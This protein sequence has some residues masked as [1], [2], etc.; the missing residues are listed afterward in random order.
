[1]KLTPAHH[2]LIAQFGRFLLVGGLATLI[3]YAVLIVC[4]HALR[5]SPVVGSATGFIV[6]A[7]FNYTLNRRFT[8]RSSGDHRGLA[9]RFAAILAIGFVLNLLLMQLLSGTLGWPYLLAQVL[10]TGVVLMWNFAGNALW[11]FSARAQ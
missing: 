6:S 4:V 5:L 7:G 1:L 2:R 11:T 10:T 3:H 9:P 8:F